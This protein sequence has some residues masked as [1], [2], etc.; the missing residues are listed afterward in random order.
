MGHEWQL[1]SSATFPSQR[2]FDGA[3]NSSTL[4]PAVDWQINFAILHFTSLYTARARNIIF[5]SLKEG[6]EILE[7]TF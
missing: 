3:C 7:S 1:I 6:E 5:V 4:P 2:Q